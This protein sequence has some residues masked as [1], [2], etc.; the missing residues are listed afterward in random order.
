MCAGITSYKSFKIILIES[1]SNLAMLPSLF[2]ELYIE[3]G[4]LI[5]L[6]AFRVSTMLLSF[7]VLLEILSK[8]ILF[9]FFITYSPTS[10]SL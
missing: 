5:A 4:R 10:T 8:S 3:T 9:Q 7:F 6:Y 2:N 1:W